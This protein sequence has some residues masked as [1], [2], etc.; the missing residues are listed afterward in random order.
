MRLF[1]DRSTEPRY[2]NALAQEPWTTTV[3]CD[4]RFPQTAPD[5]DLAEFAQDNGYV[6]FARDDDFFKLVRH[7]YNCGLLY[8][9]KGKSTAP[10][11][12]V[13][14]VERVSNAYPDHTKIEEGLP[15]NWI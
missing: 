2:V 5:R 10:G 15:G 12:I 1:F 6:V 8:F 3:W 13:T 9:R 7:Q 11:D 14:A 4:S